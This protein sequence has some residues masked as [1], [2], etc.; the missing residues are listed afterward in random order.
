MRQIQVTYVITYFI[1][2]R[3]RRMLKSMQ[4]NNTDNL[5]NSSNLRRFY[6]CVQT[7][8]LRQG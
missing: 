5:K 4:Q 7:F 1:A 6:G 3:L 2:I 8:G